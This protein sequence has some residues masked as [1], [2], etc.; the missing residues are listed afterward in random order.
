MAPA[1]WPAWRHHQPA[2]M[3]E[4]EE[5]ENRRG[6]EGE[7]GRK[8]AWLAASWL[9]KQPGEP[10]IW[11][12][13]R[14]KPVSESESGK[15]DVKARRKIENISLWQRNNG[16]YRLSRLRRLQRQRRAIFALLPSAITRAAAPSACFALA[17]ACVRYP[18][19]QL[20]AASAWYRNLYNNIATTKQQLKHIEEN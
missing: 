20:L 11:R 13:R 6:Y 2:S 7:G 1:S 16:A 15:A 17:A 18:R 19:G 10:E 4:G 5:A 8:N 3:T 12:I 9:R 14:R